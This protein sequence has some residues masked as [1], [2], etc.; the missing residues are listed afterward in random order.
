MGLL[1]EK[2]SYRPKPHET[3]VAWI[4]TVAAGAIVAWKVLGPWLRGPAS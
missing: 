3:V 1:K 4:V 2:S